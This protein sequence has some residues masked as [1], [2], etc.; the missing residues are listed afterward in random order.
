MTFVEFALLIRNRSRTNATT[1]IDSDILLSA[2]TI[3]DEMTLRIL[4]ANENYFGNPLTITLLAGV[5]QYSFDDTIA[6][7]IKLVQAKLNGTDWKRLYETDFNLTDMP[8]DEISIIAAYQGKDAEFAVF[9]QQ[10]WILSDSTV[11]G[12]TGGLQV[13]AFTWPA[14]F[15]DLTLATEMSVNTSVAVHGWPRPFQQLLLD[16]VVIDY[17]SSQDKSIALTQNEQQ[18]ENRMLRALEAISNPNLDRST[19]GRVPDTDETGEEV[20]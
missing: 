3:K 14:K 19:L 10:F 8:L 11:S 9:D 4:G 18:W 2:N 17:K 6:S 16:A 15:T 1:F 20:C 13:Y 5:R 12:V 7:Q